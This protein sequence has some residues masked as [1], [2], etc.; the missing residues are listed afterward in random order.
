MLDC[1]KYLGMFYPII[2]VLYYFFNRLRR[3]ITYMLFFLVSSQRKRKQEPLL[4]QKLHCLRGPMN[5]IY[6]QQ[7]TPKRYPCLIK[8]NAQAFFSNG[9]FG[10]LLT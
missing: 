2:Q 7:N 4:R 9:I 1:V 5:K 6:I 3:R 8:I 10:K